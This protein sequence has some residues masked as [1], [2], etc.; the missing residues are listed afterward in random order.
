MERLRDGCSHHQVFETL[1]FR[2]II[3]NESMQI[4]KDVTIDVSHDTNHLSCEE[5]MLT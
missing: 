4:M 1:S 5:N 2:Q 3:S